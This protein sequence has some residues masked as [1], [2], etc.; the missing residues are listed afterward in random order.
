MKNIAF[1]AT[2]LLSLYG[3]TGLYA[4]DRQP[5]KTAFTQ[6]PRLVRWSS[7]FRPTNGQPA[8]HIESVTLSIYKDQKDST[9][10]WHEI[11]NVTMDGEGRYTMLIGST[12]PDGVPADLF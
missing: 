5:A 10:L 9:P 6:V 1:S 4:Q 11:Q 7:S 12:I 3:A 2:I 8:A